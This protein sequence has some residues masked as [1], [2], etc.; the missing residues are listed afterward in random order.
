MLEK[1]LAAMSTLI[2]FH[3]AILL[4]LVPGIISFS[5]LVIT[6]IGFA[7]PEQCVSMPTTGTHI[8]NASCMNM[9]SGSG[10]NVEDLLEKASRLRREAEEL[11]DQVPV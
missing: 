9:S 5:P 7:T 2:S 4:L 1:S 3:I 10:D 11:K 6:R 8:A